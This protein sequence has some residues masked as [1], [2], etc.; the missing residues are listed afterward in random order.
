[1][2]APLALSA[3]PPASPP[4][5]P[6]VVS[7]DAAKAK[8]G[9]RFIE[10]D[11]AAAQKLAREQDRLLL[12]D[13]WAPWCHTCLSMRNFV[14]TDARLRPLAD[15]FVYLAIDT[16]Q[17]RNADFVTRFPIQSW[18]TLL[19]LDA[20]GQDKSEKVV[21]R[22]AGAMTAPELYAW[23]D[24]IS[25]LTTAPAPLAEADAATA[26]G[27]F[28]AAAV[29]Y[30]REASVPAV[31]GHARL[32]QIRALRGLGQYLACAELGDS[33]AA[34][35]GHNA[36][37]TDFFSYAADCL[38]RVADPDAQAR[39]RQ[40][41]RQHL[42]AVVHDPRAP[43]SPDDRSD[44]YGTLIALA[45]GLNDAALGD[46][47]AEERLQLLEAAAAQTHTPTEAATYDAHR[48][49]CYLRLKRYAPAEAMLLNSERA[50]PG[51]YNPP[52]RLGRLYFEMG[53][54]DEALSRIDHALRLANGPRRISMLELKAKIEHG[55][56]QT[57]A[58]IST[59]Q[60]AIRIAQPVAATAAKVAVL[61]KNIE[62]L[63]ST[64]V[65]LPNTPRKRSRISDIARRDP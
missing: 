42:A 60:E 24:G 54:L 18:P 22:Y 17:P 6:A 31:R 26:A 35:V 47:Y 53:R 29:L 63:K 43:L 25:H 50:M 52:A 58:A 14:F 10:D 7:T 12:V 20:R 49:E 48:L 16:E 40:L 2:V 8:D 11:F 27:H 33:A 44:G 65:P 38:E 34:D 46:R 9:L 39:L 41:L 51:D 61:Q 64:L 19:V 15:R 4:S 36:T 32:G 57:H 37:A 13:A 56:G 1:M 62:T 3:P 5:P 59:L 28:A 30:A 23:L 21:A 55:L 45:D